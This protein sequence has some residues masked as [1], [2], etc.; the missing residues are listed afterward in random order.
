MQQLWLWWGF[1]WMISRSGWQ[2]YGYAINDP[3]KARRWARW[4][5]AG[6]ITDYPDKFEK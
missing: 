4:G 2:L 5:L 1:I 3:A 6:V